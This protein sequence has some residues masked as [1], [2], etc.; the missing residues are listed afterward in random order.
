MCALKI[1]PRFLKYSKSYVKK[2][3]ADKF[4]SE[5]VDFTIVGEGDPFFVVDI[6]IPAG[7]G[8][9]DTLVGVYD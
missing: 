9:F 6:Q 5:D 2:S 4:E 7:T 1:C 8:H 3:F